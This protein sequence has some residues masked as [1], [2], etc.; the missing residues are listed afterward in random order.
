MSPPALARGWGVRGPDCSGKEQLFGG[1][2]PT[3]T[4]LMPHYLNELIV[5]QQASGVGHVWACSKSMAARAWPRN[6]VMVGALRGRVGSPRRSR[7]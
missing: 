1:C 6:Q 3:T 2:D 5:A 7:A 4:H